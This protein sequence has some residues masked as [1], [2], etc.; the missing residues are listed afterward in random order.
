MKSIPES[1]IIL[2][3]IVLNS[4]CY[5]SGHST[6]DYR[7]IYSIGDRAEQHEVLILRHIICRKYRH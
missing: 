5:A 4:G 6:D 2:H 1:T 3:G 7:H